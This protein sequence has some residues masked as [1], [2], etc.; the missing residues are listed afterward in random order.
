MRATSA[1]SV[2]FA[3]LVAPQALAGVFM[4]S[5]TATT[6]CQAGVPCTIA[7]NDDG[8]P[9][10]LAQVGLT[11]IG[12]WIGN[13]QQQTELTSIQVLDV[14]TV[15]Q[16]TFLPLA[17][18]GENSS[19]Y[20]IRFTSKG[21]TVPQAGVTAPVSYEAFSAKFTLTG[22]TG[23]FSADVKSQL[24]GITAPGGSPPTAAPP[25]AGTSTVTVPAP[26]TTPGTATAKPAASGS[27]KAASASASASAKPNGAMK[28]GNLGT[29][30]FV[31]TALALVFGFAL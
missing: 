26:T 29:A 4:T 28:L 31:G 8:A 1:F 27:S 14:S 24:A 6:S 23:T 12:L 22:M 7:W 3:A 16:I 2:A 21:L 25:T 18:A 11:D 5:P 30:G 9:P 13:A 17:T 19:L 15:A 20:F 10:T